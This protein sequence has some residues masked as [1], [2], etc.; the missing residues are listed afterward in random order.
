MYYNCDEI[1]ETYKIG[2]VIIFLIAFHLKVTVYKFAGIIRMRVLFEEGSFRRNMVVSVFINLEQPDNFVFFLLSQRQCP[3]PLDTYLA[4]RVR[5]RV[6]PCGACVRCLRAARDM[7]ARRVRGDALN[8]VRSE[9]EEVVWMERGAL[10]FA[11]TA[12]I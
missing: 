10:I 1:I 12:R 11:A 2:N 5:A 7:S 6:V 3:Y 9:G 8:I 4:C